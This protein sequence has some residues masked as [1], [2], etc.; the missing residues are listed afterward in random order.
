MAHAWNACWVNA[1]GGSNPPS[2]AVG[3]PPPAD[4]SAGGGFSFVGPT[5]MRPGG[6]RPPRATE[7]GPD[8][9]A[10][11]GTLRTSPFPAPAAAPTRDRTIRLAFARSGGAPCAG[12]EQCWL[13]RE[14]QGR[15][16]RGFMSRPAR[17]AAPLLGLVLVL[18]GVQAMPG[19]QRTHPPGEVPAVG[20]R[21]V[22]GTPVEPAVPGG[23]LG[24]LAVDP[25]EEPLL[26]PGPQVQRPED[27]PRGAGIGDPGEGI[28]EL[29]VG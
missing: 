17:C 6:D 29:G 12:S 22:G 8:C 28:V 21:G 27:D 3:K 26:G 9:R 20:G 13:R 25:F 2:S 14:L 23:Q 11:P 24:V 1:L 18:L 19:Q 15:R 5:M 7:R 4:S 10:C 16:A